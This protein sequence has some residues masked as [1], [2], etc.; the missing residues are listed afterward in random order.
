MSIIERELTAE[1]QR[2]RAGAA[3]LDEH[4]TDHWRAKINRDELDLN[5]E[6]HCVLGQLYGNFYEGL[7]ALGLRFSDTYREWRS[8]DLGFNGRTVD[9]PALTEAWKELF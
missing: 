3:F 8:R 5:S 9:M 2:A 6:C 4:R 1:Q 7:A